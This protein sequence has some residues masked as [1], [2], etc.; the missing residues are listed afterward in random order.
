MIW[1]KAVEWGDERSARCILRLEEKIETEPTL[2]GWRVSPG[3]H[4]LGLHF[5]MSPWHWQ[6]VHGSGD[7]MAPSNM[8][9]PYTTHRP[10]ARTRPKHWAHAQE[11]HTQLT[12]CQDSVI[13]N[14]YQSLINNHNSLK[15]YI[16]TQHTI[17]VK[18]KPIIKNVYILMCMR[19]YS[20][21]I[22]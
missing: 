9:I 12:R 4:A 20:C 16:R 11:G 14:D 5:T 10:A 3:S 6:T 17:I 19:I 15:H 22:L 8:V 7:H 21:V 13:S 18:I 1:G 2:K